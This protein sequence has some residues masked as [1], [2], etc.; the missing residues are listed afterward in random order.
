MLSRV[1]SIILISSLLVY[2]SR[3][4]P[5]YWWKKSPENWPQILLTNSVSFEHRKPVEGAAAFALH[6]GKDTLVCTAR[7]VIEEPMGIKPPIPADSSNLLLKKWSLTIP[8]CTDC[9]SIAIGLIRNK[10]DS[11]RDFLVL[12]PLSPIKNIQPLSPAEKIREG[13]TVNIIGCERKDTLCRQSVYSAS[14]SVVKED[15]II[16]KPAQ[17]FDAAGFSGG[18]VLNRQG[19]VIGII[20]GVY[21]GEEGFYIY[22]EPI[23]VVLPYFSK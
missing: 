5:E 9:D 22:L 23:I 15:L 7:H 14:I 3:P 10:V 17:K 20:S 4:A 16:L 1:F 2:C 19:E 8:N 12:K 13:E 21:D 6:Y 18:P 11:T